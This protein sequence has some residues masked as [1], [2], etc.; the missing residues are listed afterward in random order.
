MREERSQTLFT[1]GEVS[2]AREKEG[3]G[4]EESATCRL[5]IFESFNL[6]CF[7][8]KSAPMVALCSSI[9]VPSTYFLNNAVFPTLFL[10]PVEKHTR[11][12]D[13]HC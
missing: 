5:A 2:F 8:R 3:W 10:R 13:K 4:K 11:T 9:K 6:S 7:V 1:T 12:A